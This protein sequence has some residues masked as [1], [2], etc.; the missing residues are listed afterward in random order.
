VS[1]AVV[2]HGV[3]L[4][5]RVEL[6]IAASLQRRPNVDKSVAL[7]LELAVRV[8]GVGDGRRSDA[9]ECSGERL[10]VLGLA[11]AVRKVRGRGREDHSEESGKDGGGLH[12]GSV[13]G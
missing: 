13:V 10:E 7:D 3:E 12:L 6:L 5:L 2:Y 1:I 4:V 8:S 11:L 9:T